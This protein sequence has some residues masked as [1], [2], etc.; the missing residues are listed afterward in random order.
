MNVYQ[1]KAVSQLFYDVV[2]PYDTGSRHEMMKA[3]YG[4]PRNSLLNVTDQLR[5]DVQKFIV[6]NAIT[7][8]EF[9]QL[10]NPQGSHKVHLQTSQIVQV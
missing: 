2:V 6:N 7:M 5:R 3:G 4:D 9:R 10:D 8:S 1:S